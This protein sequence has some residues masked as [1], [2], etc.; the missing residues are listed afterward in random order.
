MPSNDK[1]AKYWN[2]PG[3]RT[4]RDLQ[5]VVDQMFKPLTD[6]LVEA[7]ATA[8]VSRV[9]DV[10]CGPGGTT[11]A[12]AQRLGAKGRLGPVGRIFPELDEKNRAQVIA[13][14]RPAFEPYVHGAEV[15]FTA[16]CWNAGARAS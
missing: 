12:L 7:A 2:G 3:G 16:S 4:W 11:L 13:A 9:L 8:S 5:A 1:Q 15:R 6:L 14:L 10:G